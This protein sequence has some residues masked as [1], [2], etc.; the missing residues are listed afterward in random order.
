[1]EAL[2]M[3]LITQNYLKISLILAAVAALSIYPIYQSFKHKKPC[4]TV[5]NTPT[6]KQV[7][8]T[9]K[10]I[11]DY[12]STLEA[13]LKEQ[14]ADQNSQLVARIPVAFPQIHPIQWENAMKAVQK[15]KAN[16]DLLCENPVIPAAADYEFVN[17]IYTTL[18][19]YGI[20]PARVE[21]EFV[22][23]PGSFLSACQG[24]EKN[25]VRH[26]IR[27]NKS[28]VN[29]KSAEIALA[30]LRHEIQHLLTYDA[31][32]L[33]IVKDIFEKNEISEQEY[34]TNPD[35]IELKKFKEYRADLLA[36]TKDMSTAQA[37]MQ[38]MEER[39]KLYPHEQEN[40]SHATHPTEAQRKQAIANLTQYMQIEK[41]HM[42]QP[43]LELRRTSA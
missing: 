18:A 30:Y 9:L 21:I 6:Q 28:E 22:T 8:D 41:Q 27:V 24:L 35:F 11:T 15:I 39:I 33:M 4:V 40:P 5:F 31:I 13:T 43:T 16:D 19:E 37:F 17:V 1:M 25:K 34:Y 29:K 32:E 2:S 26:I 7:E 23:T 12:Q 38:D 10:E 3:K 36:A 14:L 20:N 42:F